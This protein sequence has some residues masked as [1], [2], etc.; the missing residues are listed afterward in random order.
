MI[1]VVVR[2]FVSMTMMARTPGLGG[3]VLPSDLVFEASA[4][5]ARNGP[6]THVIDAA[7]FVKL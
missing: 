2:I 3:I 6:S 1:V 5:K 4:K 7:S